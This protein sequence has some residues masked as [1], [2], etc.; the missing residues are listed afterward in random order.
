MLTT[1]PETN[2]YY[3]SVAGNFDCRVPLGKMIDF[4][5]YYCNMSHCVSIDKEG[6]VHDVHWSP[7]SKE[8]AVVY[9]CELSKEER[10]MKRQ[11]TDSNV[12]Y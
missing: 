10:V 2:L 3:L 1:F 4:Y 6:A 9:G 7:N 12:V 8:F 11:I 5:D